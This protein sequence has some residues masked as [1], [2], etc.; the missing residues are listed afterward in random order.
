MCDSRFESAAMAHN[1]RSSGTHSFIGAISGVVR[2]LYGAELPIV[3]LDAK[4]K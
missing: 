4:I 1:T 2:G 3:S